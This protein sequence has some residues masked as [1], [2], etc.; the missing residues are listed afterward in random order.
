MRFRMG[1]TGSHTVPAALCADVRRGTAEYLAVLLEY[2]E[3][4]TVLLKYRR[5][6]CVPEF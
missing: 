3:Y 5:V 6:P 1:P 2:R 4:L